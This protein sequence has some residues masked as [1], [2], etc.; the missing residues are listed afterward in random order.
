MMLETS[1]SRGGMA[2]TSQCMVIIITPCRSTS[3]SGSAA[4]H[5]AY[6]QCSS[7]WGGGVGRAGAGRAVAGV[8]GA[9]SGGRV[10]IVFLAG[11]AGRIVNC[12]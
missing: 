12:L 1:H 8:R 10:D 4:P 9:V 5:A 7:R 3:T 2:L 11:R 6:Y